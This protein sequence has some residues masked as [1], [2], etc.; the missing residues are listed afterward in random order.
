[1]NPIQTSTVLDASIK[2]M[3]LRNIKISYQIF[4]QALH[5]APIVLINHA[6]TGNSNI[7]G[8]NGWWKALVGKDKTIDLNSYTVIGFNIP[9]NAYP[10]ETSIYISDYKVLSTRVVADWFWQALEVL[11]ISELYAVIGGS[12]GG[13]IA[14]EMALLRPNAIENLIPIATNIQAS[15]WLIAN[16]MV[17]DSLLHQ[18]EDPVGKARIHAMLLYRTPESFKQKFQK[19]FVE[20][21][22]QYAVESWLKY[23]AATLSKR[24]PLQAY[25]QMNHLLRTIGIGL[26]EDAIRDFAVESKATIHCIAVD[27]DYMFR[28]K[29]QRKT[30][31]KIKKHKEN[32]FFYE[33]HSVHGHDA[34]LIE[35]EQ[36]EHLLNSIFKK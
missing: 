32:I 9:G 19:Q 14:W 21:E 13:A 18:S 15:D 17:Q 22:N 29:E 20:R 35:Y 5:T 34:F 6:L 10:S 7:A 23:H 26:T 24:F 28:I 27:S 30:Y 25:K 11:E 1:M 12:L 3:Q 16:V 8:E 2:E 4:G 31:E 33:I 36:L